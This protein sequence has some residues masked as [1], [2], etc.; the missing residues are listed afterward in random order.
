MLAST[1]PDMLLTGVVEIDETFVGGKEKNKSKK[2]RDENITAAKKL[3][4]KTRNVFPIDTKAPV[5]GILERGGKVR[6]QPM[7]STGGEI[8]E[9]VILANVST[10]ATIVTDGWKPYKKIGANFTLHV[11]VNHN[12]DEWVKG[13]YSTNNIENFWSIFKRGIIGVYHQTSVK[14]LHRYCDEYSHRYNNRTLSSETKFAESV[15]RLRML[16]SHILN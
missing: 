10:D 14:H 15:R 12:N 7:V 11:S 13:P 5:L 4:D 16:G 1:E 3:T 8:L 6:V 2:K 9:P